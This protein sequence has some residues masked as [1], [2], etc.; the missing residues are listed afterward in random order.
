VLPDAFASGATGPRTA[1]CLGAHSDDIEIGCGGTLV[2]L[3]DT[4]PDLRL[5]WVVFSG[6]DSARENEARAGAALIAGERARVTVLPFRDGFFPT[7]QAAI[8][9][10]FEEELKSSEPD[11]VLTHYREDRHQDHRVISDLTWN[12]FRRSLILEYEVLKYD[13]DLGQP[14]LYV[15][16]AQQAVDQKV[17]ALLTA[18][19]SQRN[20]QWFQEDT[21]RALMRVRGVECAHTFAEAFYARKIV[22]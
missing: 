3:L 20:K 12:T 19:E 1:L 13:G 7:D 5:E 18:F 8:K 10:Y 17:K 9:E 16:L 4:Y 6:A 21:F 22:W 14:N 2:R 11:L 15:P